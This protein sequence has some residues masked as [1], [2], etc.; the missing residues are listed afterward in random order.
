MLEVKIALEFV[1]ELNSLSHPPPLI[2]TPDNDAHTRQ[3][4]FRRAGA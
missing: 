2:V 1:L 3:I 4:T